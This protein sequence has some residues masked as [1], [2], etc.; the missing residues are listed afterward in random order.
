[1][2]CQ[3]STSV[4]APASS[5]VVVEKTL[6]ENV[7]ATKEVEI[8]VAAAAKATDAQASLR[9]I[10]DGMDRDGSGKIDVAELN[11]SLRRSTEIQQLFND[12]GYYSSAK[13][14]GKGK[15][16]PLPSFF[17]QQIA[18]LD[19]DGDGKISFDEFQTHFFPK[20]EGQAD[21]IASWATLWRVYN[22]IDADNDGR[23]TAAE[24]NKALR[25]STEVQQLFNFEYF[26]T[27]ANGKG[28]GKGAPPLPKV[29]ENMVAEIDQDKDGKVSWNEFSDY[30]RRDHKL[31]EK[32]EM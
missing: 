24:L 32:H 29:F 10:F 18:K 14:K 7:E 31:S 9:S 28:K 1:M 16:P 27:S 20:I 23:I 26:S 11:Q 25:E 2:G 30:F 5:E 8:H 4:S 15:A 17:V 12:V 6:L 13:G 19:L 3:S 22:S 21:S